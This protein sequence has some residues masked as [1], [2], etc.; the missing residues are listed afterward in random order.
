MYD[1]DFAVFLFRIVTN[2]M[3]KY[4]KNI[5]EKI[6]LFYLSSEQHG[7]QGVMFDNN[8]YNASINLILKTMTLRNV[9]SAFEDAKVPKIF[10][11]FSL[12]INFMDFWML[13]KVLEIGYRPRAVVVEVSNLK[14]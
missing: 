9:Q 4:N 5:L 7:W 12:D 13:R 6:N 14:N 2:L 11:Y 3:N 10:D 1:E 8:H